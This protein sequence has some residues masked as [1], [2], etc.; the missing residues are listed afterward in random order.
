MTAATFSRRTSAT[1]NGVRKACNSSKSSLSTASGGS[2]AGVPFTLDRPV[3]AEADVE[4]QRGELHGVLLEQGVFVARQLEPLGKQQ[5]LA[6][7]RA[8]AQHPE[9]ILVK[10]RSRARRRSTTTKRPFSNAAR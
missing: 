7:G 1:D 4:S 5:L 9:V 10:I 2:S 6:H 8:V 3:A